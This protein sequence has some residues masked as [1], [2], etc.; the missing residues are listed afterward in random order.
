MKTS[1]QMR[2]WHL[3]NKNTYNYLY[4]KNCLDMSYQILFFPLLLVLLHS[5]SCQCATWAF[6][7]YS[8]P[9]GRSKKFYWDDPGK[10]RAWAEGIFYN[11]H[12]FEYER[13]VVFLSL[14]LSL[15]PYLSLSFSPAYGFIFLKEEFHT[16]T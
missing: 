9:W 1:E 3:T 14:S 10:S 6:W 11:S 13:I 16:V 2:Y 7:W 15:S 4:V 12:R 8:S 5:H